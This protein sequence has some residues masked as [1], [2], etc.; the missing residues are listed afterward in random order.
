MF[1]YVGRRAMDMGMPKGLDWML[2]QLDRGGQY[3]YYQGRIYNY[4]LT[5]QKERSYFFGP[6][7]SGG[8]PLFR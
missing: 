7:P 1:Q 5:G 3:D 2:K 6:P 8:H 4:T